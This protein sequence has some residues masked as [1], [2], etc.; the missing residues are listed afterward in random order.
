M[1]V[2]DFFLVIEFFLNGFSLR[3]STTQ[4]RRKPHKIDHPDLNA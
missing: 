2:A 1:E 4:G 3:S